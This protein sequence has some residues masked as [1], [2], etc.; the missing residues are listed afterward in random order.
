VIDD[1]AGNTM[2]LTGVAVGDLEAGDFIF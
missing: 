2:T 1:L